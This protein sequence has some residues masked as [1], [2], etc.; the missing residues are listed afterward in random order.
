MGTAAN[1]GTRKNAQRRVSIVAILVTVFLFGTRAEATVSNDYSGYNCIPI[2]NGDS[3]LFY[4]ETE[5][6]IA[7][8]GSSE[9]DVVC[10]IFKTTSSPASP[11]NTNDKITNVDITMNNGPGATGMA[12]SVQV[13]SS[14]LPA[15]GSNVTSDIQT[16]Q[17]ASSD[18]S[19]TLSGFTTTNWW[20][21]GTTCGTSTPCWKYAV[22]R[23]TLQPGQELYTYTVDEQ[24]TDTGYHIYPAFSLCSPADGTSSP[25]NNYYDLYSASDPSG[26]IQAAGGSPEFFYACYLPGDEAQFS[27]TPSDNSN[28]GWQWSYSFYGTN[29]GSPCNNTGS[30]TLCSSPSDCWSDSISCIE[31]GSSESGSWP[32]KILPGQGGDL[33]APYDYY[34]GF[35]PSTTYYYAYFRQ[36]EYMG[37]S[38]GDMQIVSVRTNGDEY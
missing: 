34:T 24:G 38:N 18:Y 31:P 29:Y 13:Y 28:E 4:D 15:S 5:G 10:E 36:I 22:L 12:C 16:H 33:P 27:I 1:G 35:L 9:S 26:F 20:G 11:A 25:A 32:S 8:G 30:G 2:I 3:N 14:Y 6:G 21:S 23:C 19:I 37:E 17:S 7:N